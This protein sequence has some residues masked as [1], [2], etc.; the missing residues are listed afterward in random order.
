MSWNASASSNEQDW[1]QV[2]ARRQEHHAKRSTMRRTTEWICKR[3]A[4][5]CFMSHQSCRKCLTARDGTEEVVPGLDL[6]PTTQAK[7]NEPA[8]SNT[9]GAGTNRVAKREE[10]RITSM[11]DHQSGTRGREARCADSR[12]PPDRSPG[13]RCEGEI[14]KSP[15]GRRTTEGTLAHAPGARQG[16]PTGE[17]VL[18]RHRSRSSHPKQRWNWREVAITATSRQLWNKSSSSSRQ[19]GQQD[20][21]HR[22]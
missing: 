2:R 6:K 20:K 8:G 11:S 4:A 12:S 1:T 16:K 21:S 17:E 22:E 7:G 13:R 15:Q 10:C 9:A 3:C 14:G 5:T 18:P 19:R